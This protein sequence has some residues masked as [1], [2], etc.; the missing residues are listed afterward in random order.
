M[1]DNSSCQDR[2]HA[3]G[4]RGQEEDG[5]G[6]AAEV[7]A[8]AELLGLFQVQGA[9]FFDLQAPDAAVAQEP[10]EA[11]QVE[12]EHVGDFKAGQGRQI[13]AD[14]AA[15]IG[16]RKAGG[17]ACGLVLCDPLVRGLLSRRVG[18]SCRI[19]VSDRA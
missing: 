9:A 3:A 8:A 7:E 1:R 13:A 15:E 11:F 4:E 19:C 14:P 18:Q 10:F 17:K 2:G 12:G 5:A 6:V 16:C